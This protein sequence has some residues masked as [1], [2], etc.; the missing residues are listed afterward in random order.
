MIRSTLTPPSLD[1]TEVE[2]LT[3][4]ANTII[5]SLD[6]D[7]DPQEAIMEFNRRTDQQFTARDFHAAAVS[8]DI[9]AFVKS[10]LVAP[11]ATRKILTKDELLELINALLSG[12]G[13]EHETSYWLALLEHNVPNPSVS[14]L[15]YWSQ[16]EMSA[17]EILA[18]ALAYQ[19]IIT[20][21]PT[22]EK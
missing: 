18:E 22:T 11:E 7:H 3:T 14:D 8:V 15:I 10:A 20:P 21:P 5:G 4:L 17:E 12:E 2:L 16:P 13:D 1:Q 6:S 9:D 19:P